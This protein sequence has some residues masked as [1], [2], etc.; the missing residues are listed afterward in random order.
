MSGTNSTLRP[1]QAIKDAL[2][3]IRQNHKD[4]QSARLDTLRAEH[5]AQT[6]SLFAEGAIIRDE[7]APGYRAYI[8]A[9]PASGKLALVI[10]D[11]CR[12]FYAVTFNETR[13]TGDELVQAIIAARM[14]RMQRENMKAAITARAGEVAS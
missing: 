6:D 1:P 12:D 8:Y 10:Y 2:W 5:Y 3:L 9:G 14:E 4:E 7:L 11:V 13:F